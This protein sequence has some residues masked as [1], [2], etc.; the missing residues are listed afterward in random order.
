[1]CLAQLQEPDTRAGAGGG[2]RPG[3]LRVEVGLLIWGLCGVGWKAAPWGPVCSG[4]SLV[5]ALRPSQG[6]GVR[7]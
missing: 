3:G 4:S 7:T 2:I 1:M 6:S 5:L